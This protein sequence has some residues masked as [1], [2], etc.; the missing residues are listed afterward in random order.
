[1]RKKK[2]IVHKLFVSAETNSRS[3][4]SS[5]LSLFPYHFSVAEQYPSESVKVWQIQRSPAFCALLLGETAGKL[6]LLT[7]NRSFSSGL[8]W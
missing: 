7:R 2:K 1:M 6:G 8:V 3:L 4:I 5:V